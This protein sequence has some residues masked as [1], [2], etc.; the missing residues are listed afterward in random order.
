MTH[1]D[2]L[3]TVLQD[4]VMFFAYKTTAEVVNKNLEVLCLIKAAKLPDFF[5]RFYVHDSNN[6]AYLPNPLNEYNPY[7]E[8]AKLFNTFRI[9]EL[10]YCLDFRKSTVRSLGSRWHWFDLLD[11]DYE[12]VLSFGI[13]YKMLVASGFDIWTPTYNE[14]RRKGSGRF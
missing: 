9:K 5:F 10:L 8:Y 7:F 11:T 13:Y 3:P 6:F 2:V 4:L 1:F 12:A 14:E